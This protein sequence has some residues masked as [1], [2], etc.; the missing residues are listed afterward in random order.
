MPTTKSPAPKLEGDPC[1]TTGQINKLLS[2]RTINEENNQI[3]KIR[4][5]NVDIKMIPRNYITFFKFLFHTT[6]TSKG[7]G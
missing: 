2:K 7:N 3:N 6:G 1:S 4:K 5:E